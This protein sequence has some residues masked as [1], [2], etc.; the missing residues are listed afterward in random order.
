M[1]QHIHQVEGI[2]NNLDQQ[3]VLEGE[4]K[5]LNFFPLFGEI[6][7]QL[8]FVVDVQIFYH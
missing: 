7:F 6:V 5:H 8:H 2:Q 3:D 1:K 4:T